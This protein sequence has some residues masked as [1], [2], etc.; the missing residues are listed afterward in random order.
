MSDF[1]QM[2]EQERKRISVEIKKLT[3][4]KDGIDKQLE[5]LHRELEAITVY[6][7]AKE[8]KIQL[9]SP[10]RRKRGKSRKAE[11]L[12]LI[13]GSQKG[14][15]RGD[16]IEQLGVKGDKSAE[17]GISNALASLKKEGKVDNPDGMY[18]KAGVA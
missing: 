10:A 1:T 15:A 7:R 14:L 12:K 16:I 13:A 2:I 8:G 11:V 6:E 9:S 17:Q 3:E 5:E 18:V 4:Q